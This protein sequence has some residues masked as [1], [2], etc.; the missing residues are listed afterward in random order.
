[1]SNV[2][3][4][5]CKCV[6]SFLPHQNFASVTFF[7]AEPWTVVGLA[8]SSALNIELFLFLFSQCCSVHEW[9]TKAL[10]PAGDTR[11]EQHFCQSMCMNQTQNIGWVWHLLLT[12]SCISAAWNILCPI[13]GNDHYLGLFETYWFKF[14]FCSGYVLNIFWLYSNFVIVMFRLC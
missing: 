9:Q 4:C 3:C 11:T 14:R 8:V 12:E 2:A 7:A 13:Q 5:V 6:F 10:P 1:M